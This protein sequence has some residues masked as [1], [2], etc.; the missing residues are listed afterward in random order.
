MVGKKENAYF[1][2]EDFVGVEVD[3]VVKAHAGSWML[4]NRDSTMIVSS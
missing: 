4:G 1:A 2:A 3:V